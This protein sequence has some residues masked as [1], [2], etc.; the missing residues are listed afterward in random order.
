MNF[1]ILDDNNYMMYAMKMY[2]NSQ[3]TEITE[4]YEDLNRIKYIKRLLGRYHT[5]GSLKDRLILNHII[6]LGN[7]FTPTGTSRMLFLKVEPHLHSY[8]K[9]FLVFLNYLP[10]SVPEVPSIEDIPLDGFIVRTLREH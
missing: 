3:C 4:F 9:T 10:N 2:D 6:I 8:L 1:P 5:K 7:V